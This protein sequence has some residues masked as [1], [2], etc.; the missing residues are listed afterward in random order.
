MS[1]IFRQFDNLKT[2]GMLADIDPLTLTS[3]LNATITHFSDGRFDLST[4]IRSLSYSRP[5]L[6]DPTG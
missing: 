1:D 6:P 3:G 5:Q 2:L 4:F